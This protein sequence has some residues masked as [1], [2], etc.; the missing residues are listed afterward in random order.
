MKRLSYFA[1]LSAFLCLAGVN[2][3]FAYNYNCA[4]TA[5]SVS[6]DADASE[7]TLNI[8]ITGKNTA[9]YSKTTTYASTL[10]LKLISSD[11]TLQGSY[12]AASSTDKIKIDGTQLV[13]ASNIR[14]IDENKVSTFVINKTGVHVMNPKS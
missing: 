11:N 9:E 7:F 1:L 3:T 8:S 5:V 6:H 14:T 10:T 13:Y 4:I 12:S 2:R